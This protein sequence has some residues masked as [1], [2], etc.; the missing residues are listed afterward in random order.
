MPLDIWLLFV[1]ACFAINIYPGPNNMVA[2]GNA[3]RFGFGH[4]FVAALGRLPAFALMIALVAVGLGVVL[5]ASETFFTA[6]KWIGAAYLV[7]LGVKMVRAPVDIAA[8]ANAAAREPVGRLAGRE[9]LVAAT[10]PKAIVT[11]T[12]F[13]PQFLTPGGDYITQIALMGA[14]FI[15][16]EAIS[17]GVYAFAGGHVGRLAGTAARMRWVNRISG[18]ALIG[19]GVLLALARR[20]E[21]A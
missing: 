5:S 3:A 21:T 6:L 8:L 20:P 19:A 14:A 12:A 11:F 17:I 2:L 7:W 9:F 18:T 4:A 1:P 15:A 16:F 10:N 13:F